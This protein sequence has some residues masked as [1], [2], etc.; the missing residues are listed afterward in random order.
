MYD[1][2]TATDIPT[3]AAMVAGYLSP[4]RFAWT[5]ADWQRFPN[6]VLVH[7]AVR[8]STDAGHVLDVEQGD[9]TPGEAVAW[10]QMRRRAGADPT[11]YCSLHDLPTVMA[12]FTQAG[13][14]PPHY[15]VAHYDGQAVLPAGVVAKQYTDAPASGGHYDLS[16]VADYWPGVDPHPVKPEA[17]MELTDKLDPN[18]TQGTVNE[19]LNAVLYGIGGVRNA[20][21]LALAVSKLT[22]TVTELS[23]TVS[24]L[25]AEVGALRGD[26]LTGSANI[27]VTLNPGSTK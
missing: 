1:S 8:A 14:T 17:E 9:A 27:T 26:T 21:S 15:W 12:A 24:T 7:I 6:A 25:L 23:A 13:V 5:V 4:S 2:I 11:V 18:A 22:E 3:T 20:G 10:V 19:A 16:V